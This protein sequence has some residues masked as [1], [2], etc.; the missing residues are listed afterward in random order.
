MSRYAE[1]LLP[2]PFCGGEK[3]SFLE[4]ESNRPVFQVS[5]DGCEATGPVGTSE[6]RAAKAWNEA[7][8]R[9]WSGA[10][11]SA[12]QSYANGNASP[13]LASEVVKAREAAR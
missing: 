4:A 6:G 2:C 9:T 11:L 13:D 12:L 1:K 10:A 8:L 5:C 3:F 7:K